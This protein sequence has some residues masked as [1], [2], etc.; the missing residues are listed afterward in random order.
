MQRALLQYYEPKNAQRVRQALQM[1]HREDLIPLLVP[2]MAR[3]AQPGSRRPV[4]QPGQAAQPAQKGTRP[5]RATARK[6]LE[7]LNKGRKPNQWEDEKPGAKAG[8][9]GKRSPKR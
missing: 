2:G 3:S 9:G 4:S 1:T 7:P 5:G 8:K 6:T